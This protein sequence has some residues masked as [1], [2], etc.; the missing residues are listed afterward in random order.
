MYI[1][2]TSSHG[3]YSTLNHTSANVRNSQIDS[4]ILQFSILYWYYSPGPKSVLSQACRVWLECIQNVFILLAYLQMGT[5]QYSR[6]GSREMAGKRSVL[7]KYCSYQISPVLQRSP[8][9]VIEFDWCVDISHSLL[10]TFSSCFPY[11]SLSFSLCCS[12]TPT[13]QKICSQ[14]NR[15]TWSRLCSLASTHELLNW[16]PKDKHA[17][18][19]WSNI[20]LI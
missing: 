13:Q 4:T 14:D 18:K 9:D 7:G 16:P 5:Q 1:I 17:C 19:C 6:A 11:L 8:T 15:R 20:I 3:N 10:Q 2:R 12:F